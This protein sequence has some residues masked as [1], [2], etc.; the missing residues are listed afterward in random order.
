MVEWSTNTPRS[1]IISS[2]L[3]KLKAYAR[4]Q[5]THVSMISKGKR[6]RLI[7]P[8]IALLIATICSLGG[9]SSPSHRRERDQKSQLKTPNHAAST[10]TRSLLRQNQLRASLDDAFRAQ[11]LFGV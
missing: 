7:T 6:T 1:S 9:R 2:R 3:R 8:F 4:Y 5:R 11:L 10:R